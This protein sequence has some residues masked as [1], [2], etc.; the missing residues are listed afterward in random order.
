MIREA[1]PEDF[2]R[3]MELYAQLHPDDPV[4]DEGSDRRVYDEILETRNLH[5]LFWKIPVQR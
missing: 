4:C 5:R 1:Q 2:G 3:V